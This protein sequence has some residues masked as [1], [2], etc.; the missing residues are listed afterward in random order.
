MKLFVYFS[1]M[2]KFEARMRN[3]FDY[4][5]L[6]TSEKRKLCNDSGIAE[7]TTMTMMVKFP[8]LWK[9]LYTMQPTWSCHINKHWNSCAS[10]SQWYMHMHRLWKMS[11][12][13]SISA[14]RWHSWNLTWPRIILKRSESFRLWDCSP[15]GFAS[16]KVELLPDCHRRCFTSHKH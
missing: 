5:I 6:K 14:K 2:L 4:L 10:M 16:L 12:K 1:T 8:W 7:S 3:V 13:L 15:R 11:Q 9:F